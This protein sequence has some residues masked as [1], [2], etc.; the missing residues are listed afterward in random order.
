[1]RLLRVLGAFVAASTLLGCPVAEDPPEPADDDT[2]DDDAADDDTAD[3]DTSDDDT[4][5]DDTADD[6]SGDDDTGSSEVTITELHVD[7]YNWAFEGA[8]EATFPHAPVSSADAFTTAQDFFAQEIDPHVGPCDLEWEVEGLLSCGFEPSDIGGRVLLD[9]L[10]GEPIYAGLFV[11]PARDPNPLIRFPDVLDEVDR[12]EFEPVGTKLPPAHLEIV[13]DDDPDWFCAG[14]SVADWVL[15]SAF[16]HDRFANQEIDVWVVLMGYGTDLD[17]WSL[18]WVVVVRSLGQPGPAP[19][20]VAPEVVPLEVR[21]SRPAA[22]AAAVP[23]DTVPVVRLNQPIQDPGTI[24]VWVEGPG[25]P[26]ATTCTLDATGTALT[27]PLGGTLAADA[28]HTLRVDLD[29]DG[30]ADHEA[31][32]T[33]SAAA[34]LT[35][36]MRDQLELTSLGLDPQ[37]LVDFAVDPSLVPPLLLHLEGMAADDVFPVP[38]DGRL[39]QGL[40]VTPGVVAPDPAHGFV[41]GAPGDQVQMI[42]FLDLSFDVVPMPMTHGGAVATIDLTDVYFHGT[43]KDDGDVTFI[44][45]GRLTGYATLEEWLRLADELGASQDVVDR[46]AAELPWVELQDSCGP[47]ML[48]ATFR[49]EPIVVEL[50]P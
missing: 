3:D 15:Q 25:G 8:W 39:G 35:F 7:A 24:A 40:D 45:H 11:Y 46:L 32:F 44:D 4:A 2:S 23:L 5:D 29:L 1:M 49:T 33:T 26:I 38:V 42:G 31:P 48:P 22:E 20:A 43:V 13:S 18:D 34:G 14:E 27:C 30:T 17:P 12:A 21:S 50:Q 36:D 19:V 41:A 9:V 16:L 10:S 28:I 6:D 47:D 37:L